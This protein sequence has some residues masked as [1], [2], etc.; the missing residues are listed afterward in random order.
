MA[1]KEI[2]NQNNLSQLEAST[3]LGIPVRTYRKYENGI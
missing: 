3:I 2:R 1:L